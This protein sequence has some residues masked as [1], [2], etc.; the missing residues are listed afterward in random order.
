MDH[1]ETDFLERLGRAGVRPEEVDVVVCTHLHTDHVGW[2]T[3]LDNDEWVPT[4][5]NARYLFNRNDYDFWNPANNHVRRALDVHE[6]MF[7][8]SVEPVHR[9]GRAELWEDSYVIDENL[10]VDLAPG[11]TPGLGVITLDSEGDRAVFVGDILQSPAQIIHPEWSG[12]F[13]EDP[14]QSRATRSRVLSWAADNNALVVPAHF[15]GHHA[16][17]VVHD[18]EGFAIKGWAPFTEVDA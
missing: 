13:C 6:N 10:R 5:P 4:F 17:E 7:V 11:H 15:D 12:C 18:G 2:N 8:D 3:V 9:A 16:A 1:L 14:A